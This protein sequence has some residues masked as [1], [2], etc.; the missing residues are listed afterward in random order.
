MKKPKDSESA[1][2]EGMRARKG[3]QTRERIANEAIALFLERGFDE[4]TVDEISAAADVSK[5]SFFDYFPAKE[6]VVF[7]WQ[8]DFGPA[9]A[10]AVRARPIEEPM[11]LAVE[12]AFTSTVIAAVETNP[13]AVAIEKL[14]RDTPALRARDHLKYA[15]IEKALADALMERVDEERSRFRARMLAVIVT[16]GLRIANEQWHAQARADPATSYTRDVFQ[17]VWDDLREFGRTSRRIRR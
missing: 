15:A 2:V 3:R 6:D 10:A 13:A 5:R 8:D 7:A 17:M 16:G 11:A 9:L 4:V 14:V 1:N 12:N